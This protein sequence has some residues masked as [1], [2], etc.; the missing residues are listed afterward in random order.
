MADS[1]GPVERLQQW[2]SP[3]P[4]QGD[5]HRRHAHE[6]TAAQEGQK[7]QRAH[8]KAKEEGAWET[9]RT[10]WG[11]VYDTLAGAIALPELSF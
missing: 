2:Y 3:G 7:G 10:C 8:P 9:V 4:A 6:P 5:G 1:P 11:L